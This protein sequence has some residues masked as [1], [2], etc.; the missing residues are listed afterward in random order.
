MRLEVQVAQLLPTAQRA[1]VMR[2]GMLCWRDRKVPGH[3]CQ[4]LA[5]SISN[6]QHI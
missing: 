4:P 1:A 3:S 6:Y 5:W 2:A